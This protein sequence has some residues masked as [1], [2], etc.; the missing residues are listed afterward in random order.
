MEVQL[1]SLH[2]VIEGLSESVARM[3]GEISDGLRAGGATGSGH[4]S[5]I[6]KTKNK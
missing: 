3:S 5:S 6:N 1:T 4:S 2:R